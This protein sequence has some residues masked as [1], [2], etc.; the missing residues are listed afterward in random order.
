MEPLA[1]FSRGLTQSDVYVLKVTLTQEWRTNQREA[2][3]YVGGT[4]EKILWQ[5]SRSNGF[6]SSS[7]GETMGWVGKFV[8]YVL[9]MVTEMFTWMRI[10]REKSIP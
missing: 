6:K 10:P 3:V 4:D 5:F 9:E 8:S 2:R 7:G 1:G